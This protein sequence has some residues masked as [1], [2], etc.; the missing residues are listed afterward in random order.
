MYVRDFFPDGGEEIS[1]IAVRKEIS[2]IH[3]AVGEE[4]SCIA[5]GK[6]I[7]YIL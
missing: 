2:Y 4:I 7:S 3:V 6:E 5:V 1:Y